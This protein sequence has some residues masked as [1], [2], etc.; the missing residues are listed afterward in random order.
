MN[1]LHFFNALKKT[2]IDKLML[3]CTKYAKQYLSESEAKRLKKAY[4]TSEYNEVKYILKKTLSKMKAKIK[5][6]EFQQAKEAI[7]KEFPNKEAIIKEFPNAE[8]LI[9]TVKINKRG[10]GN[11]ME[12][13]NGTIAIII[14][15]VGI[16]VISILAKS[17]SIHP[18]VNNKTIGEIMSLSASNDYNYTDKDRDMMALIHEL[19]I[20]YTNTDRYLNS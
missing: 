15:M 5:V 12:I 16:L 9:R 7:I 8:R 17:K 10:Q 18:K 6:S 11:K 3:K 20:V 4:K 1:S 2:T 13:S 19:S 14:I